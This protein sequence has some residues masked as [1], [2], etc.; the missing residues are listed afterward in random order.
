MMQ[1]RKPRQENE[2]IG[3]APDMSDGKLKFHSS[4]GKRQILIVEDELINREILQMVLIDTY[5]LLFA[6][7]GQEALASIEAHHDVLSLVLLDLNLPD[8]HGLDVLKQVK[9]DDRFAQIPIIVMT[10]EK[11]AE[12]ESLTLGAMDFIPK[13]YPQ[14]SIIHARVLRTIELCE[15]RDI[16]RWTE[17]DQLT[18][19][20]NKEYFYRYAAQYD[21]YHKDVATDAIVVNINR[22]RMINE[23]YGR[24]AGNDVLKHVGEKL[25]EAVQ[26][27]GG[28]VCRREAD[29][30]LVYCPHRL[31]Y[32]EILESASIEATGKNRIRLRMGVYSEVD[33]AIDIERRFDRAK[34][35][36]DTVRNSYT[37]AVAIYDDSLH[38]AE[39]FAEQLLEDFRAAIDEH[40]F[41][42]YFQP[43]F[44][45]RPNE[46]L[47]C[48]AEVLVRWEHPTLGM[49][50]PG[51][52]IPLFEDNGMITELDKYVWKE[53]AAQVRDWRERLGISVPVSVNV[54]RIDMYDPDLVDN[55]E[56]IVADNELTHDLILLEITESAYTQDSAQMID[57][58]NLLR[59]KGF[60]IEM[61]DF[62]S[63]YSSLNMISTLP[64]DALKL[65][66]QFI[67]NAFKDRKDTRLLEM[68]I[69]LADSLAVPTIAEGVE[70]AEQLFTLK[71]M[72]CA[73]VQGYYFSKPL[74]TDEFEAYLVEH[75]VGPESAEV[76][77]RFG[78]IWDR[79]TYNAL[80][81]PL[82]GMYNQSAFDILFHDSDQ[83]HIGV[84]LVHVDGY[85]AIRNANGQKAADDA[86]KRV[87][88]ILQES[89]R[90]VDD[91]C[92][93]GDDEFVVIMTR[94]TSSMQGLALSKVEKMNAIL[95]DPEYGTPSPALMVGIAFSDRENPEGDIF[96]DADTALR[97]TR[98]AN[99]SGCTVF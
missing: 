88:S 29:T 34:S 31:D 30:F 19:L 1:M 33:K 27:D 17:R 36:A 8:M 12:V 92:R 89:F 42:L 68:I 61:D 69:G 81:D 10:A 22:F 18:G 3:K 15:D 67:R 4:N 39:M 7:T 72:G 96:Q 14:P 37:K 41:K 76:K 60:R 79:F 23:R 24:A 52:F 2:T 43:K 55:L 46:P 51:K 16:I 28:I 57:T 48:S 49:V 86:I 90:S 5:D 45:V 71:A 80:H 87:A 47:L 97:R 64:I 70:T 26:E 94:V 54:S 73:I 75:E 44:D 65:D 99:L 53:A 21:V 63:G 91:I 56:R 66:M 20:Y 6:E 13:P 74:P 50:M 58:V 35:A 32:S 95:S 85:Q 25:R 82:T 59:E 40:Q 83:E 9:A 62:G 11:D 77:P 38:E 93:L 98:Q 78:K 84:L